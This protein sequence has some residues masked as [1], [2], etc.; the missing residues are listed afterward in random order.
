MNIARVFII[1]SIAIAACDS[2]D[3]DSTASPAPPG[4]SPTGGDNGGMMLGTTPLADLVAR[5]ADSDPVDDGLDQ[6]SADIM[7]LFG[8]ANGE[9]V[10]IN[11]DD[12]VSSIVARRLQAP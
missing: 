11:D 12:T 4:S 1:A 8:E 3:D 7:T 9:P 2:N 10:A 6:V 5:P